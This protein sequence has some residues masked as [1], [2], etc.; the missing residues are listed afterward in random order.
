MPQDQDNASRASL[1]KVLFQEFPVDVL[2]IS[3]PQQMTQQ[4]VGHGRGFLGELPR[5]ISVIFP[6]QGEKGNA[7][8]RFFVDLPFLQQ[9]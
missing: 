6:S 2:G 7:P 3:Q 4:R 5:K 8:R 1:S 9:I